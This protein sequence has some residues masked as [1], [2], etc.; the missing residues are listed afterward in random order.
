MQEEATTEGQEATTEGQEATTE[1]QEAN[2]EEQKAGSE[3]QNQQKRAKILVVDDHESARNLLKRRLAIYG[4]DVI[5]AANYDDAEALIAEGNIDVIF[6]NMF[7]NGVN[8]Y[9][10]LKGLKANSEYK[11][12]PVV[13]IS[14]DGDI[15]LVVKCIELGAEDYLVKPLNQTLLRARLANCI[16][17][18]EAYDKETAYL[19]K[20]EQGQKQIV[21][22]EKMAS[23]GVLVNSIS[24]E[25]KN[26]LNFVINFGS[27][28]A[29]IC[30]EVCERIEKDKH[31]LGISLYEFLSSHL[32]KFQSNV[33]K[34]SE[35]G[36]N[37]DKILRF[38]LTQSNDSGDKKHPGNVNKVITQ[39]I[40]MLMTSYKSTGVS[41]LP[42][43][44]TEL[45]ESIPHIMLS[46][47][48]LSR[49][50]YNILDNAMYYVMN[51][52]EETIS[53]AIIKVSSKNE[54][55][56]VTIKIYDNGPGIKPDIM[57]KIFTPFFTTKP[58]GTG[59]G[60]G[61]SSAKEV[62]ESHGGQLTVD[63]K[64]N[65]FT[66]FSISIKKQS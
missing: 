10:F 22:Q 16:A 43:I 49:A 50:I 33:K 41:K 9:D 25:L 35:Y 15:E 46:A 51:K 45:D 1:E 42:G 28:S 62:I 37:A 40:S 53:Q 36:S 31:K 2:A 5:P 8:S 54:Q 48:S 30:A 63:S 58:E 32:K 29:E 64:E 34:I 59:P 23:I 6:L 17:R 66:E 20:I 18:K 12:I 27:V 13:M 60:L 26:P 65:E 11:S 39:T 4:Y 21:A 19:A 38:M 52:Y 7:L 61:L 14:S 55:D 57:D 24:Q 56:C 44:R 47:Q 3:G